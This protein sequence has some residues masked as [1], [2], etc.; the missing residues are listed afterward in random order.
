MGR[1]KNK[2]S[3]YT[4]KK[5]RRFTDRELCRTLLRRRCLIYTFTQHKKKYTI[6]LK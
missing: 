4:G 6:S 1:R 5:D 2:Y 3:F